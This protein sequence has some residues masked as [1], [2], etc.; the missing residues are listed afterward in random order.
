MGVAELPRERRLVLEEAQLPARRLRVGR[1]LLHHLHRD[2]ALPERIAGEIDRA[3][4][5]LAQEALDLVLADPR[6]RAHA[7]GTLRAKPSWRSSMRSRH[8]L[9]GSSGARSSCGLMTRAHWNT[10]SRM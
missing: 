4:R 6:G 7:V 8:W 3:G 9:R 10:E 2:V 5:A 1:Q